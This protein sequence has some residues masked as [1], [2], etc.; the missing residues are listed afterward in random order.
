MKNQDQ[1]DLLQE[2]LDCADNKLKRIL[3]L[4]Q[5]K[6][7]GSWLTARPTKSHGFTLNKQQFTDSICLRYGW[8]IPNTPSHCPCNKKNDIDIAIMSL[9][10]SILI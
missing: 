1:L 7:A 3:E 9:E 4:A 6:G 2:V 8:R 5:E 10:I